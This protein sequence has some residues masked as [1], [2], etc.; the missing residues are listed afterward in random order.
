MIYSDDNG[1]TW[2][3]G[4]GPSPS[5]PANGGVNEVAIVQLA[6]GEIYMNSRLK[7]AANT[8]PARGYSFSDDGGITWSNVQYNY[9]LP[10]SSVEGSLIQLDPNTLLFAAPQDPNDT[11]VRQEMTIWASFDE[12]QTWTE[13]RVIN[14]DFAS[15]SCMVALGHDTAMLEFAA[16]AVPDDRRFD[17][18]NRARQ[19]QSRRV[20]KR[21]NAPV[22]LDLQ[23]T[24]DRSVGADR[25]QLD[26][27]RR[28]LG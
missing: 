17:R 12:G 27:R 25:R 10:V 26:S 28:S 5:D 11:G 24:A 22:H 16:G 15:Y 1:S 19:I 20:G 18:Q 13:E 7:Y 4:G 8:A 6:N 2:Q 3:L 23:R 21:A 14:Y 9:S